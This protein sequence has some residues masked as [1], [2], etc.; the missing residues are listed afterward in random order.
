MIEIPL[1][2]GLTVKIDDDDFELVN[3][4]RWYAHVN[5]RVTY[6]R[7]C[8]KERYGNKHKIYMHRL[9]VPT[10]LEI[11][12][13]DGDG[14]NN[15]RANL[16]EVTRSQN[17]ANKRKAKGA[18][19]RMKGVTFNKAAG[20]WQASMAISIYLGLFDTEIEAAIAYNNAAKQYHG[21]FSRQNKIDEPPA[22]TP[23]AS[24]I[25]H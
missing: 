4:Y 12:H 6:A 3:G 17:L 5:K 14:L 19:S 21:K 8:R 2:R 23:A 13:I 15:Q 10:T 25:V 11:D 22:I 16:R 9:I 24:D 1:T 18:Y 7:G 20:K